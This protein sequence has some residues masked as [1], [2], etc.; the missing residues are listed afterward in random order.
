ML[1]PGS[2]TRSKEQEPEVASHHLA[3][4]QLALEDECGRLHLLIAEL[5]RTNQELRSQV[6]RLQ[7]ANHFE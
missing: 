3:L 5:L 7:S 2:S 1:R 6:G 4:H